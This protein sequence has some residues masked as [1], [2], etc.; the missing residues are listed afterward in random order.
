[1]MSRY[2]EY[3]Y[4]TAIPVHWV[5]QVFNQ[6]STYIFLFSRYIELYYVVSAHAWY[7]TCRDVCMYVF[8]FSKTDADL[9]ALS[10]MFLYEI[11]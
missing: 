5:G 9:Y 11:F 6:Q 1:M 10:T 3:I 4:Q 8:Y 7:C 2:I